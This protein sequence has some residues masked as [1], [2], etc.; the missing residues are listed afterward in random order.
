MKIIAFFIVISSIL[1][2]RTSKSSSNLK[3][4][5][6]TGQIQKIA[7]ILGYSKLES[8]S[9]QPVKI[10]TATISGNLMTIDI[11]YSGGCEKHSFL[12]EGS[13]TIA[14]SMPAVRGI[15]LIHQGKKRFV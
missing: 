13:S 2:C 14:K 8:D 9:L 7:A 5:S 4:N 12:L 15:R 10:R 11:S 6:T 3:T 1:G